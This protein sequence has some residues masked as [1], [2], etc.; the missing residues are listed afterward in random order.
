MRIRVACIPSE[1]PR[2]HHP[3]H[4][5]GLVNAFQATLL[6]ERSYLV[7]QDRFVKEACSR[8]EH[9]LTGAPSERVI[10]KARGRSHDGQ[11]VSPSP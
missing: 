10:H 9:I 7:R 2:D 3:E 4:N 8:P 1:K 6:N 11:P 5:E